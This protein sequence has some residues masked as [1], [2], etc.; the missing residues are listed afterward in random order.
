MQSLEQELSLVRRNADWA[1]EELK[2]VTEAAATYR[3]SKSS[4]LV[5]LQ[6]A[7]DSAQ[8]SLSSAQTKLANSESAYGAAT[9]RLNEQSAKIEELQTRLASQEES[10]AAEA[11][12]QA[13][14]QELLQKRAED[15]QKREQELNDHWQDAMRQFKER[16]E[17][18]REEVLLERKAREEAEQE[19]QDVQVAL[20]RLAESVGIETD[21]ANRSIDTGDAP[22]I[23]RAAFSRASTPGGRL[24]SVGLNPSINMSP[25][26]ALA[27]KLQ[28]SGMSFTQIY[29]E[30]ARTQEE[31]R[32]ER[33]ETQ[34]LGQVLENMFEDLRARQPVLQAQ[35]EETDR[36]REDLQEMSER[37]ASMCEEKDH[38]ENERHSLGLEVQRLKTENELASRNLSDL[39]RQVRALTREIILRDDPSAADRLEDDGSFLPD[40]ST[41]AQSEADETQAIISAQLVTF[42]SLT[43]LIGQNQRLLRVTRELGSRMEE[44]EHELRSALEKNENAAVEEAAELIEQLNEDLRAEKS[45]GEAIKRERDMFRNMVNSRSGAGA[46]NGALASNNEAHTNGSHSDAIAQSLANQ[47]SQLQAHFEAYKTESRRDTEMLKTDISEARQQA[48]QAAVQAARE[49]ASKEA[50]LGKLAFHENAGRIETD[51][52]V[53]PQSACTLSNRPMSCRKARLL[54]SIRSSTHCAKTWRSETCPRTPTQRH[55]STQNHVWNACAPRLLTCAPRRSWQRE[56]RPG[57]LLKIKS[58]SPSEPT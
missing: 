50:T 40:P 1:S 19:K 23:N 3:T 17:A 11:A 4:E 37:V 52:K 18:I 49:K 8:Q 54:S 34:R 7:L 20:D 51:A 38:S 31:L 43:D 47:Y 12:T 36:L 25:T 39:G 53:F 2:K 45:R 5:S 10:F 58:S 24:T 35:R 28:R 33:L 57:C 46:I 26:A 6:T 16:E 32:R 41:A 9:I 48:S 13:K 42:S 21:P 30:L 22:A 14:L 56:M 15:A 55:C 44:K 27:S 29:T